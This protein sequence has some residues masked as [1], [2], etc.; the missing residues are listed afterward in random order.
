[1]GQIKVIQHVRT[2]IKIPQPVCINIYV[3]IYKEITV[4]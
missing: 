4:H 1:M 3:Y 2:D